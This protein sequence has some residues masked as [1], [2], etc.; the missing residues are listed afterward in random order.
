[1]IK[2]IMF[3]L[4]LMITINNVDAKTITIDNKIIELT[5]DIEGNGYHFDNTLNVLTLNNY[6]G[7]KIALS[8][9]IH[10]NIIGDNIITDTDHLI[11]ANTVNLYGNGTL[12]LVGEKFGIKAPF[13][14][15]DNISIIGETKDAAFYFNNNVRITNSY[16]EFN[17][18]KTFLL[19]GEKIIITNSVI[20]SNDYH[21]I[22]TKDNA[23]MSINNSYVRLNSLDKCLNTI[24]QIEF[25]DSIA[26]LKS[27]NSIVTNV[28]NIN[29]DN[30]SKFETSLDG[31]NYSETSDYSNSSFLKI[32]SSNYILKENEEKDF[33][34]EEPKEEEKND[35]EIDNS[36]KD[37]Q[38]QEDNSS[39]TPSENGTLNED[40][41][42]KNE[43]SDDINNSNNNID[44]ENSN[45][46]IINNPDTNE[47]K[48]EDIK[49]EN[50]VLNNQQ[51]IPNDNYEIETELE[52]ENPQ[53]G[54]NIYLWLTI[55]I[56]SIILLI[57]TISLRRKYGK[58]ETIFSK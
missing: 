52:I 24:A 39:K 2:K 37:N 55:L 18:L 4:L 15:I 53:T 57:L 45:N 16:I 3:A 6:Q 23:T 30:D 36:E 7:G 1:M 28:N 56:S 49:E 27:I 44:K 38:Q 43:E 29:I 19:G 46:E 5:G 8:G 31:I 40:S 35:T 14:N 48:E 9:T 41:S 17:T 33:L 34:I 11:S 42:S 58:M 22:S 13:I 21:G 26:T 20:K 12:K 47:K 25:I 54:D 51:T 32:D 10:I 50:S